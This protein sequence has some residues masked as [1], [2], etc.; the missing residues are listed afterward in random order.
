MDLQLP[1]W[2]VTH[3]MKSRDQPDLPV[4][5]RLHIMSG[6]REKCMEVGVCVSA[7]PVLTDFNRTLSKY[8]NQ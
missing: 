6:E 3:T 1:L 5:A 8:L 7:K 2:T 4:I